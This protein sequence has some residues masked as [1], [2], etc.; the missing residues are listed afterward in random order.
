MER[1]PTLF[2]GFYDGL[3]SSGA[4]FSLRLW[5][6]RSERRW[7]F[8]GLSPP[9][10]LGVTDA[11]PGGGTHLSPPASWNFR[12]GGW[13]RGGAGQH[14]AEFGNLSVDT[15]LLLFKALDGGS[16]DFG[17]KFVG[18]HIRSRVFP[19]RPDSTVHK[20]TRLR[21]QGEVLGGVSRPKA[22]SQG[23]ASTQE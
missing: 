4:E 11:L 3:F 5:G 12:R 20:P 10:P 14:F 1:R 15:E 16:D 22:V 18:G 6:L 23:F 21:Q 13:G 19:F 8:L 2:C 17:G 7:S 9:F